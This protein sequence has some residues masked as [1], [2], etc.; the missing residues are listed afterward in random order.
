MRNEDDLGLSGGNGSFNAQSAMEYLA[1]YGWAILIIALVLAALFELGVFNST[2]FAPRAAAG[3]CF[4]SR[5]YGP[6]TTNLN[7]E[8]LCCSIREQHQH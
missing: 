5:P 6:N 1:T 2:T 3:S 7:I 4:V 8:C